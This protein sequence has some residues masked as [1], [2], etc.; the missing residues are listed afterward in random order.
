MA[1]K[2]D[3]SSLEWQLQNRFCTLYPRGK[4]CVN[5]HPRAFIFHLAYLWQTHVAHI[6]LHSRSHGLDGGQ[7]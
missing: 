5:A 2:H 4:V 1:P 6:W 3:S 7:S